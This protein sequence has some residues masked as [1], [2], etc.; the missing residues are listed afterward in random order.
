MKKSL[1]ILMS[2]SS[3][4]F[5]QLGLNWQQVG[6]DDIGGRTRSVLYDKTDPT[7]KTIFAGS[8]GGGVFKSTD[9]GSSWVP[10]NDQSGVF[11][12]SC[13][14]QASDG[15]IYVGTGERFFYRNQYQYK[16]NAFKGT[17]L[18]KFSPTTN[19]FTLVKDSAIFGDI[20][21]IA[22]HP[23][24]AQYICVAATKGFFIST[25]GGNTFTQES[26]KNAQDV[27]I[28]IDGNVY[29]VSGDY[30]SSSKVY[31]STSGSPGSFTDIT[32]TSTVN[33]NVNA[34]GRIEIAISP[35][36]PNYVYLLV[37]KTGTA[38]SINPYAP[39]D[40]DMNAVYASNDKGT[41]WKTI[42]LGSYGQFDIFQETYGVNESG[43]ISYF[44]HGSFANTI[45]VHPTDP[46][47]IFV[48]GYIMYQWKQSP[49][50]SFGNGTWSQVGIETF[51]EPAAQFYLHPYIH[52]IAFRPNNPN[53]FIVGTNGGLF[54]GIIN[55]S[56]GT[57]TINF[58]SANKGYITSQMHSVSMVNFPTNVGT[59]TAVPVGG[60]LGAA[61]NEGPIYIKGSA[62][63]S[64]A[65]TSQNYTR[66]DAYGIEFSKIN[67]KSA[68]TSFNFGSIQRNT[69]IK[70]N[71]FAGFT[72]VLYT[73][74]VAASGTKPS[75]PSFAGLNTPIALWENW[76]QI[77]PPADSVI[78]WNKVDTL[79]VKL[80]AGNTKKT[81]VYSYT[82]PQKNAKYDVIIVR[83]ANNY[84][85]A[86]TSP[87]KT[88]S[89]FP[90][91]TGT[92]ITSYSFAGTG[93]DNSNTANHQVFLNT[94]LLD[95]IKITLNYTPL[96]SNNDSVIMINIGLRYDAGDWVYATNSDLGI[97][98]YKHLDSIQL[99][100]PLSY[101]GTPITSNI[102]KIPQTRAARLAVGIKKGVMLSKRI[103]NGDISPAWIKIAG[104]K[105]RI[106]APG[107]IPSSTIVAVKGDV[108]NIQWAP[109]GTE[110]YFSTYDATTN[111]YYLYRVSH[112]GY[113]GDNDFRD[114]SG[115]FTSDIDSAFIKVSGNNIV[116][117]RTK[118]KYINPIRTTAIGKFND[119]ITSISVSDD[120]KAVLIT[121]GGYNNTTGRVLVTTS[122]ARTLSRNENDATNFVNKTSNLPNIPV[123]ASIF[124]QQDN[125]KVVI[126]TEQG[127]YSTNDITQ[128]SPIWTQDNNGQLPAVPVYQLKQQTL[129]PWLCYNSGYIY[130]ATYGRGIWTTSKFSTP[131]I[132]SVNE[133]NHVMN[134]ENTLLIYPN[135]ANEYTKVQATLPTGNHQVVISVMDIT[136]KTI[137]SEQTQIYSHGNG[138]EIQLNTQPLAP[139][140]YIIQL[141]SNDFQKSGKVIISK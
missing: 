110:L 15:S 48:G 109:K 10:V 70:T 8:V 106:D 116:P 104:S 51:V 95:S 59:N 47:H 80:G 137:H 50:S 16:S 101:T 29:Y 55:T 22:T 111:A 34:M 84:K 92:N 136:G 7:G 66:K 19:T 5:A 78:L 125:K 121:L 62:T 119:P 56:G 41:T 117:D 90:T 87:S 85:N 42:T 82:R 73:S 138:I 49:S 32:P 25:D 113:I 89:I 13:M 18:Y 44:Y 39:R 33:P 35:S 28:G 40:Q 97:A 58:L 11:N 91:Y 127:V 37:A 23:T 126:G 72:D 83:T 57:T 99:T 26:N 132:V 122:D 6:P 74:G 118:F 133:I 81:F 17:G 69:N 38:S 140:M 54:K 107:G 114:Y 139:G 128:S 86:V 14:S 76:G 129:D 31:K 63:P 94:N 112:L 46:T 60:A 131:Y 9:G 20:N 64:L 65:M 4:G 3:M 103:L 134:N 53:E 68:F 108:T 2:V 61:Y 105:S 24:N 52:D 75:F 130:A 71:P 120:G 43:N 77:N 96:S 135:P 141:K 100:A 79:F 21:E 93:Y 36:D 115:V 98:G 67:D 124:L 12:I 1:A 88:Y 123:Y 27:K 102:V 30:T 45:K